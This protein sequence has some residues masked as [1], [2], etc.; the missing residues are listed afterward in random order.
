M[1][2]GKIAASLTGASLTG[3]KKKPYRRKDEAT[4]CKPWRKPYAVRLSAKHKASRKPYSRLPA[5]SAGTLNSIL[6]GAVLRP[7][8]MALLVQEGRTILV[9]VELNHQPQP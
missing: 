7:S 4:C 6:F 3:A 2:F 5:L 8:G 9:H 1:G